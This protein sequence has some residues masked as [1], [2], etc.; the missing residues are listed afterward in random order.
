[1]YSIPLLCF[2]KGDRAGAERFM[3]RAL[4]EA[5]KGFGEEDGHVAAAYTNLA[6]IYK[7]LKQYDKAESLY[8]EVS[9][10]DAKSLLFPSVLPIFYSM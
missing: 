8:L 3:K 7:N 10:L 6:E 5:K 2:L 9:F 1:M 4:E